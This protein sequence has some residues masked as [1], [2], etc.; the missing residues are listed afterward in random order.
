[1]SLKI[2][3]SSAYPVRFQYA[4]KIYELLSYPFTSSLCSLQWTQIDH[5][6]IQ[7]FNVLAFQVG[8]HKYHDILK[9]K[10]H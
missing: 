2:D 5:K 1:M 4:T 6:W 7:I 8:R 10:N 9:N 3:K